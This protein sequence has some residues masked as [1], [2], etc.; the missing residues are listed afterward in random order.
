MANRWI[1]C[2]KEA[3]V[4]QLL[5]QKVT[6]CFSLGSWESVTSLDTM[7]NIRLLE[8]ESCELMPGTYLITIQ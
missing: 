2:L 5:E 4:S 8:P 1:S 7:E 3:P 6:F